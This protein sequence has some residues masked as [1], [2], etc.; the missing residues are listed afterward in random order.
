MDKPKA[1]QSQ[2]QGLAVLVGMLGNLASWQLRL[3]AKS[4]L[5]WLYAH[6]QPRELAF[7]TSKKVITILGG[8]RA[9]ALQKALLPFRMPDNAMGTL[10]LSPSLYC[11]TA[12]SGIPPADETFI[13]EQQ[14]KVCQTYAQLYVQRPTMD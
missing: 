13:T 5:P 7:D 1:V 11:T 6:A 2:L 12:A 8:G 9:N 3:D 14:E 4:D 10:R